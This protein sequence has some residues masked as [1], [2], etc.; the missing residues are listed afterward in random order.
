MR[1]S[2][3]RS[4]GALVSLE[5][6]SMQLIVAPESGARFVSCRAEGRDILRPAFN[7]V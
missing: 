5:R 1:F 7:R 6:G 3:P 4:S 2:V